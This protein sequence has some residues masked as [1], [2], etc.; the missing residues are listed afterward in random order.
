MCS[1]ALAHISLNTSKRNGTNVKAKDH[2][3]YINRD[4]K[5]QKIDEKEAIKAQIFSG[6]TIAGINHDAHLISEKALYKNVLGS[7]RLT[8]NNK[9]SVSDEASSD[10]N[11]LA[12]S[13][14]I[15]KY[16]N[17]LD[18]QGSDKFKA[19]IILAATNLE[20]DINFID[21]VIDECFKNMKDEYNDKCQQFTKPNTEGTSTRNPK[22]SIPDIEFSGQS[23]QGGTDSKR[24]IS[25]QE[26][27]VGDVDDD[28]TELGLLLSHYQSN[29]MDDEEKK[30]NLY[31]RRNRARRE[32]MD[33]AAEEILSNNKARTVGAAHSDYINRLDVFAIKGGCIY[34]DNYL[35]KWAKGSAKTFF[36]AADKYERKNGVPYF[37]YQLALQN[38][39]TIEQNL[40][41]VNTFIKKSELLKDK[42]Y[43][44]AIHDKQATL[45]NSQRQIH[46]HLMFSSRCIDDIEKSHERNAKTFFSTYRP[47]NPKLGGCKKDRRFNWDNPKEREAAMLHTRKLW[48]DIVNATFKKY[49]IDE[50]I[51]AKSLEAQREKA[52]K[53]KD[54]LKAEILNR[55]PEKTLGPNICSNSNEPLVINIKQARLANKKRI[56]LL[57]AA[58]ETKQL[59]NDERFNIKLNTI[60]I[61]ANE[62]HNN[63]DNNKQSL[64]QY[65]TFDNLIKSIETLTAQLEEK[66]KNVISYKG[67]YELARMR[68][69][70]SDEF[71]AYRDYKSISLQEYKL[72]KELSYLEQKSI[73]IDRQSQIKD[74]LV[75][76]RDVKL[77]RKGIIEQTNA[78]LATPKFKTQITKKANIILKENA[79][80]KHDVDILADKLFDASNI[81]RDTIAKQIKAIRKSNETLPTYTAI[82]INHI[83]NTI[84]FDLE[85][86]IR[87]QQDDLN[88]LYPKL[89]SEDR[90]KVMAIDIVSGGEYKRLRELKAALKKDKQ[91]LPIIEENIRE[92]KSDMAM[93]NKKSTQYQN[94]RIAYDK[95]ISNK[96]EI[97]NRILKNTHE[98][99]SINNKISILLKDPIIN[100]KVVNTVK[101]ILNKNLPFKNNYN[102]MLKNIT[103]MKQQLSNL[104]KLQQSIT[105]QVRLDK[106][107]N[108]TYYVKPSVTSFTSSSGSV[109][110][111]NHKQNDDNNAKLIALAFAGNADLGTQVIRLEDDTKDEYADY[112]SRNKADALANESDR[113]MN[114]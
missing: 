63:Y 11:T 48:E 105:T 46:C 99:T 88:A 13:L 113:A 32:V 7:I 18:V 79:P 85:K 69:M 81:L 71:Y 94:L 91:R 51:S 8:D 29:R 98:V 112:I 80:L 1:M 27:S 4:G 52:L 97:T 14:A 87:K 64:K 82:Q 2:A 68:L 17:T 76:Y 44:F 73:K 95:N 33:L 83:V 60:L 78:R 47:K 72:K 41:I 62:S 40:E 58:Y 56:R 36:A 21:P 110:S 26:L 15:K 103:N 96:Q 54:Y 70:T 108:V 37:E 39:L 65:S 84:R 6:N 89:I 75:K 111:S 66:R 35:P 67:A 61:N 74:L 107:K 55:A 28:S 38:E 100:T 23:W 20:Y 24:K 9:I 77:A 106:N 53:Q 22:L 31:L 86:Q 49:G 25:L 45:D 34:K 104:G 109:S 101:G 114:L 50:E 3:D 16:G 92:L 10:T 42:Y 30:F 57:E 43:A 12:L 5:Y 90:A 19:E 102:I 93:L 59:I